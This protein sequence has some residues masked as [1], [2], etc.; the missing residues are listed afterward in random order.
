MNNYVP[1]PAM[2]YSPPL[3]HFFY[4]TRTGASAGRSV[5]AVKNSFLIKGAVAAIPGRMLDINKK[6]YCHTIYS[7]C[8][9]LAIITTY[10]TK[11]FVRQPLDLQS[12][13]FC[14]FKLTT[15]LT[16]CTFAPAKFLDLSPD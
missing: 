16:K 10:H 13:F 1:I 4:Q 15:K 5:T 6:V 3:E 11:G 8:R 12:S 14:K 9:K 2:H 7:K